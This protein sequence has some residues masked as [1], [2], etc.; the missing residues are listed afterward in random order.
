VLLRPLT[1]ARSAFLASSLSAADLGT[2]QA[3]TGRFR[4]VARDKHVG[5]SNSGRG[6]SA[7]TIVFRSVF[8][9]AAAGKVLS[10]PAEE[11]RRVVCRLTAKRNT[12]KSISGPSE[13]FGL[14]LA[15]GGLF[16]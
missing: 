11:L 8:H 15:R 12:C 1:A 9:H 13:L 6:T 3:W 4:D 2:L 16:L 10:S 14:T 5:T 7:I